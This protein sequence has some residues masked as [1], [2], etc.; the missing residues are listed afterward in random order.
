MFDFEMEKLQKEVKRRSASR[1]LIQLPEGLKPYGPRLAETIEETGAE[2]IVAADPC[3]GACDLMI[4]EAEG[5]NADLVVHFGHSPMPGFDRPRHLPIVFF[6]AKAML[7]LKPAVRKALPLLKAWKRIGLATTVQHVDQLNEAKEAL[8]R[9][10]K[11][12]AVGD[13]GRLRYAG[14]VTGCDYS[15][16]DAITGDVDCFLFVGGG[17]FHAIG[18][19]LATSKPTTVADPYDVKVFSVNYEAERIRKQRWASIQEATRGERFGILIGLK[20]GQKRLEKAFQIR[21]KLTAIGKKTSLLA[22][23]EV[24]S[25]SLAEFPTIDVYVNTA[26]PRISLDDTARFRKPVLTVNEALVVAGEITWE[27]LLKRGWLED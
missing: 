4:E 15:N 8:V 25:E 22:V 2:A 16:V 17:H 5:L 27:Q 26:C 1:V 19:A 10:G 3:Y 21:N 18:V 6:E 13:A 23:R 9:A 7:S 20:S 24:A 11:T 12:V 14:Q